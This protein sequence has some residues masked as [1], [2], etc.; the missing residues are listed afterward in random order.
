MT[1]ETVVNGWHDFYVIAGTASATLVGLLFVGLSLHLRVV[2]EH[3]DVR[4]F[5]RITLANFG[6][7]LFVALFMVIPQSSVAASPQLIGCGVVWLA[8]VIPSLIAA[9]RSERRMLRLR[10]VLLRYGVSSLS[11]LAITVAG[12]LLVA[13]TSFAL[14]LLA[15]ATVILLVISLRNT[16]DLLVTVGVLTST[17]HR[18]AE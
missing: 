8:V 1:Y 12:A 18:R 9:T 3:A 15:S 4:A 6:L 16:W 11:F 17:G 2:V 14:T 10:D 13:A 5:A 7:I